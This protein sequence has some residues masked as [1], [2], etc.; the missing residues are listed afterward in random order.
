[1]AFSYLS[2]NIIINGKMWHLSSYM[3]LCRSLLWK[4]HKNHW[5]MCLA[6][7]TC[8]NLPVDLSCSEQ[9]VFWGSLWWG[10]AVTAF[11]KL[12]KSHDM[13][14]M[15]LTYC[16]DAGMFAGI[17]FCARLSSTAHYLI[18]DSRC[19]SVTMNSSGRTF[20]RVFV[21]LFATSSSNKYNNLP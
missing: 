11:Q 21:I 9:S 12:T 8:V 20:W 1:V 7:S 13:N 4:S 14:K 10:S 17:P 18:H 19:H 2:G 15:H 3:C 16:A 6:N 5:G